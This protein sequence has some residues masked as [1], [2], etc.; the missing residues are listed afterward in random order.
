MVSGFP[1]PE[2]PYIQL[3]GN[4]A[5]KYHTIGGIMGPN[6]LMVVYVDPLDYLRPKPSSERRTQVM[7]LAFTPAPKDRRG[8]GC[9]LPTEPV[10]LTTRPYLSVLYCQTCRGITCLGSCS[11]FC[12]L[13]S[14][15]W[16]PLN[17][18]WS[19]SILMAKTGLL[20]NILPKPSLYPYLW[21]YGTQSGP[22]AL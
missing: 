22:R 21:I 15:N 12:S 6:S 14:Q 8:L 13:R 3:L 10:I 20:S 11:L 5:A 2:G 1:Y 4:Q 17:N 19:R 16:K 18:I 9:R 7:T